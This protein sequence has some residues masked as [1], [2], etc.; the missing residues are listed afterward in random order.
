MTKF[1]TGIIQ[2]QLL[3]CKRDSGM[4]WRRASGEK[5][6]ELQPAKL[7]LKIA[8]AGFESRGIGL[9]PRNGRKKVAVVFELVQYMIHASKLFT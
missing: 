1:F 9:R 4:L 3:T 5:P 6:Y 7:K 2:S 8:P